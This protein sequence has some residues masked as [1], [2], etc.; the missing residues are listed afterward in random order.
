MCYPMGFQIHDYPEY[1]CKLRKA[2]YGL[3]QAPREWYD[4]IFEFLTHEGFLVA[5]SDFSRFVKI[6]AEN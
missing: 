3:N 4:E 2:L 5:P 6:L 1:M